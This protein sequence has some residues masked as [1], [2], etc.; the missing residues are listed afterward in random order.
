MYHLPLKAVKYLFETGEKTTECSIGTKTFDFIENIEQNS[1][2]LQGAEN[3]HRS[4][5]L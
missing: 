4:L 3:F 1:D 2:K 5:N